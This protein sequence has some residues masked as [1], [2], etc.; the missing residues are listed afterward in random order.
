[1]ARGYIVEG[2]FGQAQYIW[3]EYKESSFG[4]SK[5]SEDIFVLSVGYTAFLNNSIALEPML[6]YSFEDGGN[7]FGLRVGVQ[8][9]LGRQT[10]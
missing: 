7:V 6:F 8:A 5:D 3:R 2:L 10:E 4:D 9:F 1:M